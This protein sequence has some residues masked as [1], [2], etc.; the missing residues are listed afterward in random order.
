MMDELL[1]FSIVSVESWGDDDSA[2]VLPAER[3]QVARAIESRIREFATARSCARQALGQ[4]GFPPVAILRGSRGEPIW[5]PGVA[6]SI[7][8]CIGYRAAAVTL[9][10][11]FSA[12]GIDA[13]VHDQLP[14]EVLQSICVSEEIA[15]LSKASH[16]VHWDRIIFSA[17]ESVYKAWFP[18]T[19]L[20]LDF[21]QIVLMINAAE[22]TFHV[23][24]HDSIPKEFAPLLKRLLGRFLVR[25][26]I[27]LTAAIYP[28]GD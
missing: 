25:D 15:W 1:P 16:G 7:T 8:H 11:K 26:G 28:P 2:N 22:G 6:G 23:R 14:P 5:P 20:W 21:E 24:P 10:T 12:I 4:L 13:E 18:L 17:K 9:Q 27:V 3:A 19:K